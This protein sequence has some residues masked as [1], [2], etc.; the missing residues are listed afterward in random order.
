M[1]GEI[2][3]AQ[4]FADVDELLAWKKSFDHKHREL[5]Q[6]QAGI[7]EEIKTTIKGCHTLIATDTKLGER[8]DIVNKRLRHLE[9]AVERLNPR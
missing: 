5:L 2:Q 3:R 9:Q 7:V 8:I 6:W 4:L 1:A